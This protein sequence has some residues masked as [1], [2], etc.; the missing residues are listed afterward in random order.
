MPVSAITNPNLSRSLMPA[1][2]TTDAISITDRANNFRPIHWLDEFG[3]IAWLNRWDSAILRALEA[4]GFSDPVDQPK[5]EWIEASRLPTAT[6][7]EVGVNSSV[8]LLTVEDPG[9]V[10]KGK[11]IYSPSGEWMEVLEISLSNSFDGGANVRVTRGSAGTVATAHSAGE[12]LI[13]AAQVLG[14]K[15]IPRQDV[16][17]MPGLS[18]FN[19]STVFA[20]EWS[21]TRAANQTN[22]VGNWGSSERERV[23]NLA[24]LRVEIGQAL[25]FQPRFADDD[26]VRG[27]RWF[28][29]GFSHFIKSN[30]LNLDNEPSKHTPENL[31]TF[32]HNLFRHE[33]SSGEK[34]AFCGADLFHA[35]KKI[36]RETG[37]LGEMNTDAEK[38]GDDDFM[39]DAEY[40]RI[41]YT[42][43]RNDLPQNPPYNLGAYG[44]YLDIANI[45]SGTY[46][47]YGFLGEYT[48]LETPRQAIQ[49][50]T[51]AAVGSLWIA[52]YFEATHGIIK[53]A[54]SQVRT[55]RA[56]LL[57]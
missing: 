5:F 47:D 22:V 7:L 43:A 42:L 55:A 2:T 45:K 53:G 18:Q 20:K 41:R 37:R 52:P 33:S 3:E 17:T 57:G 32:F 23:M 49:V 10:N 48:D 8:T 31:D 34:V 40:G 28:T 56:E 6:L 16:G 38:L 14:E 54:P 4:I 25:Y 26:P 36:A 9:V 24:K 11:F 50:K 30:V 27:P 51:D 19:L 1:V 13:A 46:L 39:F 15:D 12:T 21:A 29:G 44:F 35:H